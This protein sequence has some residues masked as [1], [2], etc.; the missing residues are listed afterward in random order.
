MKRRT[1]PLCTLLACAVCIATLAS[2]APPPAAPPVQSTPPAA[3]TPPQTTV[4]PLTVQDFA[5]HDTAAFTAL[6]DKIAQETPDQIYY[7]P[8][9]GLFRETIEAEGL[10]APRILYTYIAAETPNCASSVFVAVPSGAAPEEFLVRSG[11]TA[12]AD[13]YKLLLHAF[14]PDQGQWGETEQEL[15]YFAAAYATGCK[16]V[17]YSPYTGNYYFVGYGDGGRLMQ[18]YVMSTPDNCAGMAVLDG[19]D[20]DAAYL[21]QMAQTPAVDPQKTVS[22]INVPVW[23][24]GGS[25]A[26]AVTDYWRAANRCTDTAYGLTD[27]GYPTTVYQQN[28]LSADAQLNAYPLGKV[29]VTQAAVDYGDQAFSR[30]V[31]E[32]FLSQVQ[33]YRSLAGNDLRPAM[34]FDA[35]GFTTEERTIDG[36]PRYWLEYVPT[37]VRANPDRKAPLV[38]ALHGA[39]QRA[40]AYA[41]YSEW[42][43]VAEEAGFIVVYPTAYPYAENNGMAR[44][45]HNDCWSTQRPDDVSFWT[46]IIADVSARYGIDASRIYATG[47]SNG[48]NSSNMIAAEMSD[49]VAAVAISAGRFRNT[50][51]PVTEDMSSLPQVISQYPVPLIQL[52]GTKDGGCYQSGSLYSTMMFWLERNGCVSLDSP[53]MYR[54]GLYSNQIWSDAAGVPMVRFA[55]VDEKPH[56][57]TPSESRLFW[58]EFLCHYARGEDG[59]VLY[60]QDDTILKG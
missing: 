42:H 60:M 54:T 14:A 5:Y 12:L 18:Q 49:L 9:T 32:T 4:Q 44:P 30:T 47:H 24:I 51:G 26:T 50:P 31:W 1:A 35:L 41:P 33:R 39:G 25:D 38:I 28:P 15:L 10:S 43:K 40:E 13:E 48:G 53:L 46:Q 29:Q 21:S 36:Y 16:T 2:C 56:T 8:Y 55:L 34:D 6:F 17:N 27:L 11:W 37:S 52:V 57:T 22:Q 58:Y 59:S 19:S 3:S 23:M 45:I 20:I 7:H